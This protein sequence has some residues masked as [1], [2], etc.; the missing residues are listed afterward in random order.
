MKSLPATAA[1]ALCTRVQEVYARLAG[2]TKAEAQI[3]YLEFL[4]MWC[5]FYGSTFFDVQCQYDDNPL[6]DNSS[7]P[8]QPLSA[9]VGPLA[10]F[11]IP[12]DGASKSSPSK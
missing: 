12:Q 2:K 10:L 4:R 11:L 3:N 9:A 7:P 6:D 8:V 5:P 1:T